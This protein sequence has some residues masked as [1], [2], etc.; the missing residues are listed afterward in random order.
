MKSL[1]G[2]RTLIFNGIMAVVLI[3]NAVTPDAPIAEGEVQ[4]FVDGLIAHADA[5]ITIV[6]NV[7]LRFMTKTPVFSAVPGPVA[8]QK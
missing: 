4:T 7:V 3:Y 1:V 2:Y 6:G 5:L 8:P